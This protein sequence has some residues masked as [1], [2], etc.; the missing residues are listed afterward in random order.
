MQN[1]GLPRKSPRGCPTHRPNTKWKFTRFVSVD[2]KV[3][4]DR[5]AIFGE[6]RL[7]DWLTNLAHGHEMFALDT[8]KDQ[9]CLWCCIAVHRGARPDRCTREVRALGNAFLEK[10]PTARDGPPSAAANFP[11]SRK[12][13]EQRQTI[14][15]MARNMCLY[16]FRAAPAKV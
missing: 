13:S 14:G 4:L 11:Q 12:L 15:R 1:N 5:Q 10:P 16:V 8:F 9:L 7:P 2:I 3:V 6:G